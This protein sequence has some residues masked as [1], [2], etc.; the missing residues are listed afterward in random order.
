MKLSN[1]HSIGDLLGYLKNLK[2]VQSVF[3]GVRCKHHELVPT[4]GRCPLPHGRSRKAM[5]SRLFRKFR[6]QSIP[7]LKFVPR[8]DWEW[9]AIAQHYGLPTRLLDW[10]SNPLVAA[11]FAV[12]QE[13]NDDSAI[14]VCEIKA[15]VDTQ[16][17]K[18]PFEIDG[19]MKFKP[20]AIT[21]RLVRQAGL[22]TVC[23]ELEKPFEHFVLEKLIIPGDKRRS[24]KQELF[25]LGVSRASLFPGLDGVAVNVTWEGSA[26]Y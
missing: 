17:H 23:S 18:N 24:I 2:N 21:E 22:F 12:E 8:D 1:I 11:Y 19:V 4:I 7:Y 10:T 15:S 3:R 6:E 9:L 5:E 20:H 13:A 14:Y 26:I 25:K 16:R